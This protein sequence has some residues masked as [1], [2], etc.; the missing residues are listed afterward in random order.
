M[1]PTQPL[2]LIN[3]PYRMVR[4]SLSRLSALSIGAEVYL[5]NRTVDEADLAG[6]RRLGQELVERSIPC[7]V[8]APYMD[9]T[10]GGVDR[11]I[12]RITVEKL[13]KAVE[14]ANL[15]GPGA[16]SATACTTGGGSAAWRRYGSKTARRRGRRCSKSRATA[17]HDREYLRGDPGDH[18]RLL[19]RFK[20]RS[21]WFCFDTGHFN[22]FYDRLPRGVARA[23]RRS[24]SGSFISTTTTEERRASAGG[25][26]SFPFPGAE[27]LPRLPR[28][29]HSSRRR[30]PAKPL[31]W[32][33]YNAPRSFY[34]KWLSELKSHTEKA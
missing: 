5:D 16:W 7:T 32:I 23:A 3:V 9:L 29:H 15:L 18:A 26:G 1:P 30:R 8:H 4:E 27:A 22:L 14:M 21:L 24:G 31:Q 34:H 17:A 25:A 20:K 11:D 10:P 6:A 2:L 28:R 33:P 13:K 12:R 19:G